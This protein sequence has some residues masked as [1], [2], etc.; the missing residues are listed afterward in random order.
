MQSWGDRTTEGECRLQLFRIQPLTGP[1]IKC[2]S[3]IYRISKVPKASV[4]A[5]EGTDLVV[6]LNIQGNDIVNDTKLMYR[7][8]RA[9]NRLKSAFR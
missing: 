1:Q 5:A 6:K 2:S 3:N 7:I 8:N 9:V 4:G